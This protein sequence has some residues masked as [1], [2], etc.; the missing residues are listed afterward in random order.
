MDRLMGM[1][2]AAYEERAVEVARQAVRR[3]GQS[4]NEARAGSFFEDCEMQVKQAGEDLTRELMELGSQMRID[5][6][7]SSFSPSEGSVGQ[8]DEE[9]RPSAA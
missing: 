5:S 9:Q 8:A 6:T 2:L 7:E 3:I 4:I 1:D